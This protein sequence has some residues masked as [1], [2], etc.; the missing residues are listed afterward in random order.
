[1]RNSTSIYFFI[2]LSLFV[3]G[4]YYDN[5]EEL[6]PVNT[7]N[8]IEMSYNTD[9]LPILQ[10]NCYTCHDQA[11][12]LGGVTLEGYANLIN[13]VENGKLLGVIKH[14]QGF[15]EMP[16]GNPQLAQCQIDKIEAWVNQGSPNN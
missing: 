14:E 1:M 9:V 11:S 10:D 4:C 7:C 3:S 6:Y 15:P 8:T 2:M 16:L 5:E 12:N 13:Y